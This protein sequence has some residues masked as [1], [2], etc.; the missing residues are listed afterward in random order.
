MVLWDNFSQNLPRRL[1]G[2]QF[3]QLEAEAGISIL[4]VEWF[5]QESMLLY[6]HK[7]TEAFQFQNSHF[8]RNNDPIDKAKKTKADLHTLNDMVAPKTI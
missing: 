7:K 5:S 8:H 3:V 1:L 6:W 4:E 2:S